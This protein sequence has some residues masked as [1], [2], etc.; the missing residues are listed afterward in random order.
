MIQRIGEDYPS[1]SF[2]AFRTEGGIP[3]RALLLQ[4]AMVLGLIAAGSFETVLVLAQIPLL[5]CLMLGVAGMV[6]LRKRRG[7]PADGLF[8]CP[9]FPLPPLVFLVC[10]VA[11]ILHAATT[12]PWTTLAGLGIMLFP[13]LLHPLLTRRTADR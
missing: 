5:L 12:R 9:L 13:L 10:C 7:T 8:R 3:R 4:L 1:L 6:V 2:L 11:G